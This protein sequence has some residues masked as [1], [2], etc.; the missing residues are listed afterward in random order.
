MK[1]NN[2]TVKDIVTVAI[3]LALFF[4]VSIL[5]GMSMI[6]VPVVYI[7]G[8]AG[9]EM[10]IGAIFYLV[11]A[12]R[13]NK[14]G[15]L[16]IWISVYGLITAAMGYVFML[17]YFLGVALICE[18]AMIGNDTYRNP[19]RNMIGWSLYGLG[20]FMGI[21]VPIWVAWESYQKQALAGGFSPNTLKMQYNLVYSPKLLILGAVI[22]IALSALG[23]IFGQK[24]LKKHFKKAGILE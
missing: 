17:P 5:I 19:K 22:T 20:M 7:Y 8:T 12:N 23:I 15:L 10:F 14:H 11:A 13:L 2:M 3:M 24:L 4:T 1:R 21:G 18:L 16:F 9:I 6:A